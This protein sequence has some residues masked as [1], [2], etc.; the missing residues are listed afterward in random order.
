MVQFEDSVVKLTGLSDW[1]GYSARQTVSY[2]ANC[3][4]WVAELTIGGQ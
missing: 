3:D 4:V 1:Q 2:I